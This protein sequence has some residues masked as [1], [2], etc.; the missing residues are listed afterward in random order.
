[1]SISTRTKVK[2]PTSIS[3]TYSIASNGSLVAKIGWTPAVSAWPNSY[4][5]LYKGNEELISSLSATTYRD[6]SVV[7]GED[8]VYAVSTVN[9]NEIEGAVGE[10]AQVHIPSYPV[11]ETG[12]S[13]TLDRSA[14][15]SVV[16][17]CQDPED[18]SLTFSRIGGTAPAQVTVSAAG[19]VDT[20]STAAG[21]YLLGIRA[22][23]GF[24]TSDTTMSLTVVV[25]VQQPNLPQNFN[26]TASGDTISLSW[27]A[28][29]GGAT[30]TDYDA[31]Y[32][33]VGPN[34]P[35]TPLT[36]NG[37]AVFSASVSGLANGTYYGRVEA[38]ANGISSGF[39]TDSC[40]VN[41]PTQTRRQ[42]FAAA[43][44]STGNI[45]AQPTAISNETGRLNSGLYVRTLPTNQS[46]TSAISTGN[47]GVFGTN[48]I[49]D[50]HVY[51]S[52]VVSETDT[53]G[54]LRTDTVTPREPAVSNYFLGSRIYRASPHTDMGPNRHYDQL[55][56]STTHVDADC[57]PRSS[58]SFDNPAAYG[59]E[60]DTEYWFG[61]SIYAPRSHQHESFR[62][63]GTNNGPMLFVVNP[64]N[65]SATHCTLNAIV[66]T[67][68]QGWRNASNNALVSATS[69]THWCFIFNTNA[70]SSTEGGSSVTKI[71]LGSME[72]DLGK[73]TD[74]VFRFRWN[75]FSG[76]GSVSS[77]GFTFQRGQGLIQIWKS[78]GAVDGNGNR[79]IS[80]GSPTYNYAGPCGL[81][82][83]NSTARLQNQC[84]VYLF[85]LNSTITTTSRTHPVDYFFSSIRWGYATGPK[86]A[87][88][89]PDGAMR[90]S[91]V[92]PSS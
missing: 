47:G 83:A 10:L 72:P 91:D 77:G 39:V 16:T 69:E 15:A 24:L 3:A 29:S 25:P 53:N 30:V 70:N 28:P 4:H 41:V 63:G 65:A 50:T 89:Q 85:G 38:K 45:S 74:F 22:S 49:Y 42:P 54:V 12:W 37:P 78:T 59:V 19:D 43:T 73:W 44:F 57:K 17:R 11:W 81:L 5:V 7:E 20:G 75:P 82:P 34:G 76:T 46:G 14:S 51:S 61:W 31:D 2:P 9:V 84:R 67:A 48:S 62:T 68:A 13:L 1:M 35:W 90:F 40:V 23:N 58:F 71:S 27:Q 80:E 64:S 21:S 6:T 36:V 88:W 8:A 55:N 52:K 32:S 66:P 33:S 18:L 79:T 26:M 87:L 60:W 92:V 56:G 86:V